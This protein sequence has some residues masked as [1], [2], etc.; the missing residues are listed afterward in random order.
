M[1]CKQAREFYFRNRDGFLC[2]ADKMKLQEHLATCEDCS[3]FAEEM[4]RSLGL[5]NE[6]EQLSPSEGFEWN[7][8]RRILLEKTRLLRVKEAGHR[9][10]SFAMKFIGA[11][12]AA[13]AVVIIS[14]F[15]VLKGPDEG[16]SIAENRIGRAAGYP[17]SY[18]SQVYRREVT[19]V[20]T[21]RIAQPRMV[22]S[23]V[24]SYPAGYSPTRALPFETTALSYSDSLLWEN[25]LL[26]KRVNDL[27][28]QVI[29]LRQVIRR[30][31]QGE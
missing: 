27:E 14:V 15:A 12:A 25:A 31:Q 2:E 19:P 29:Y 24:R 1:R 26:R 23:A 11:T 8:K 20:A 10:F 22:S 5:L 13:A 16:V 28:K 30:M 3:R 9:G 21:R 17:Y 6:L 4:D 7:V 18:S